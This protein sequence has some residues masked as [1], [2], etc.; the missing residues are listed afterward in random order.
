MNTARYYSY[1]TGNIK[2]R[3]VLRVLLRQHHVY[4]ELSECFD[5]FHF[6]ILATREQ[7]REINGWISCLK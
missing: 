5:M 1:E 3:N 4:Y 7:A 6:E 2:H